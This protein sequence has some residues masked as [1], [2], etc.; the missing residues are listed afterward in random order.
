MAPRGSR[1]SLSENVHQVSAGLSRMSPLDT[2]RAFQRLCK[3]EAE[4][5]NGPPL[6]GDLPGADG[7][8]DRQEHGGQI[9]ARG[10]TADQGMHDSR[11][12]SVGDRF[13]ASPSLKAWGSA[14]SSAA[15]Q[16]SL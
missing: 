2:A 13:R 9:P 15:S 3:N 6:D 7:T 1:P 8:R 4:G 10:L 14:F 16:Y 5:K 11:R 12:N